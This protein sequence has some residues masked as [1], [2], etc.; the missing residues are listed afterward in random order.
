MMS[1]DILCHNMAFSVIAASPSVDDVCHQEPYAAKL[2]PQPQVLFACG[3][4]N[5]NPAP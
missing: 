3:F 2:D 5:L 4:M 1:N